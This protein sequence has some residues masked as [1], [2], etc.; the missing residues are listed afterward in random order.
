M[1]SRL[2]LSTLGLLLCVSAVA[3]GENQ[4]IKEARD[5]KQTTRDV[6]KRLVTLATD[7][8]DP[9]GSREVAIY[10]LGE[11][12][13]L[14]AVEPLLHVLLTRG[15]VRF[16]TGPLSAYPAALA[17]SNM[18]SMVYDD[19]WRSVAREQP[20]K[21]LYVLAFTMVQIDG[22]PIAA[23]RVKEK[24]KEVRVDPLKANLQRLLKVLE[25]TDFKDINRWPM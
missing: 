9:S 13:S 16:E 25:T 10:L 4:T 8:A 1:P 7:E 14:D 19:V 21:Y 11:L 18:G 17:L 3:N 24:L 2:Y 20:D 5:V 22:Q 15:L 12:R 23:L 6:V